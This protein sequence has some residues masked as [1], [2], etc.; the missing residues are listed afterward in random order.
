MIP[1]YYLVQAPLPGHVSNLIQIGKQVGIEKLSAEGAV[2]AFGKAVLL[3][4]ARLDVRERYAIDPIS[5]LML[6]SD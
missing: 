5:W 4:L 3:A 6:L 2:E 1:L